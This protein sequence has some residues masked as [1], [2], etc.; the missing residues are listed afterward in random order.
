MWSRWDLLGFTHFNFSCLSIAWPLWWITMHLWPP[1]PNL[2]VVRHLHAFNSI[3]YGFSKKLHSMIW[4]AGGVKN[5]GTW[6]QGCWKGIS[7]NYGSPPEIYT[8]FLI[9][10]ALKLVFTNFGFCTT[11]PQAASS[12][13][14]SH[15]ESVDSEWSTW[16]TKLW[17]VQLLVCS[18][19]GC[20]RVGAQVQLVGKVPGGGWLGS[21]LPR[22]TAIF[23]VNQYCYHSY[24]LCY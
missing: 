21:R 3:N 13:P 10:T 16:G 4:P 23:I 2:E 20:L 6:F 1:D 24:Y 5:H 8:Y 12:K 22:T 19:G 9:I 18:H 11:A 17:S 7:R 15:S 14:H